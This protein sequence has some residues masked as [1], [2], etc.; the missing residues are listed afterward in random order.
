MDNKIFVF[1]PIKRAYK[2]SWKFV[3]GRSNPSFSAITFA[4]RAPLESYALFL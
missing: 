1:K 3:S 4:Y 2:R